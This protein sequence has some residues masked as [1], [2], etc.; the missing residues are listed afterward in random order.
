VNFWIDMDNSPHVLFFR[1]IIDRLR[2]DGHSVFVTARDCFQVCQLADLFGMEYTRIGRHSGK[3]KALKVAG[4]VRRVLQLWPIAR[5]EKPDIALSHGSRT[6]IALASLLRVRSVSIIDY[7]HAHFL[8]LLGPDFVMVPEI[9]PE[10]TL[11]L[12]PERVLKYPGIKED[13]YI[14]D[15]V[16]DPGIYDLLKV[17]PDTVL[18]TI[19]P[20]AYH[21][22]YHQA[23]SDRLFEATVGYLSAQDNLTM[24]ILPRDAKQRRSIEDRWPELNTRGKI[25][26]PVQAVD[27]L[28]LLWHSDL[29]ISGGGTMN[30]EAA[31]LGVPVYSIF[32]SRIGSVDRYLSD[33]GRLVL[34]ED[35]DDLREISIQKRHRSW[36]EN[37][38]KNVPALNTIVEQ[39]EGLASN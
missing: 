36:T 25:L 35:P 20:P 11:P 18:V 14:G 3:N 17:S 39:V 1:P 12:P 31:A 5:R 26:M 10:H 15:F 30:R 24:V 7:E 23:E 29:V 13:V 27:G 19:R 21:A 34:L 32:R 8:P 2:K 4:L 22:H 6:Q 37:E 33:T 9:I 16:P 38:R 28:N